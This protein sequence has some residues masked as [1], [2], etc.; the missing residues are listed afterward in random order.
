MAST[1]TI[2]VS[3]S[4]KLSF[5]MKELFV[6]VNQQKETDSLNYENWKLVLIQN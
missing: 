4:Q 2:L 1:N 3:Q 6:K 5:V